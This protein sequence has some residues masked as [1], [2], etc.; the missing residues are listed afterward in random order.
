MNLNHFIRTSNKSR[1]ISFKFSFSALNAVAMWS[2]SLCHSE[3]SP[4][5]S[6]EIF[7]CVVPMFSPLQYGS[8]SSWAC[9]SPSVIGASSI[10]V[11]AVVVKVQG[12]TISLCRREIFL[13]RIPPRSRLPTR[14]IRPLFISFLLLREGADTTIVMDVLD[15][16]FD[17]CLSLLISANLR[18]R[19]PYYARVRFKSISSSGGAITWT[20]RQYAEWDGHFAQGKWYFHFLYKLFN[21]K[22]AWYFHIIYCI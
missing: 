1:S 19:L 14:P 12:P 8:I 7:C 10:E 2:F 3:T 22:T 6:S 9:A 21:H 15:L 17:W 20:V 5:I 4:Y 16:F 11:T 13:C 18:K